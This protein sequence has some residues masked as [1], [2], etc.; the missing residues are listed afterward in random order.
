MFRNEFIIGC[1]S[2]GV[3][4]LSQ[5]GRAFTVEDKRAVIEDNL[6][7]EYRF[8]VE[9]LEEEPARV[10]YLSEDIEG[11][12]EGDELHFIGE[13]EGPNAAWVWSHHSKV[14]LWYFES[15]REGLREWAY[16]MW[17]S[18]R[19]NQWGVLRA[20]AESLVKTEPQIRTRRYC[21]AGAWL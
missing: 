20:D 19:L 9:A 21:Y 7:Y 6:T 5:V 11:P 17:D 8:L 1:I 13:E 18:E 2:Y 3:D 10:I 4:L 16:V 15:P 12:Q 14:A